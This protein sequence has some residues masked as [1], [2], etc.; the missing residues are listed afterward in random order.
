MPINDCDLN[1]AA[2]INDINALQSLHFIGKANQ[3]LR[4]FKGPNNLEKLINAFSKD[5]ER[6]S[7]I[8]QVENLTITQL[9]EHNDI[10]SR[11]LC[12]H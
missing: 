12:N 2:N 3:T 6:L 9:I 5:L 10:L 1:I 8:L 4:L 7:H 11:F